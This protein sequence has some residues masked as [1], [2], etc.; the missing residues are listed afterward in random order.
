MKSRNLFS[1][2]HFAM[3]REA[4]KSSRRPRQKIYVNGTF[5]RGITKP[6]IFKLNVLLV[7]RARFTESLSIRLSIL[8]SDGALIGRWRCS[9]E[10]FWNHLV[11]QK[12]CTAT[13][14]RLHEV[15]FDLSQKN[16]KIQTTT[17]RV[18]TNKILEKWRLMEITEWSWPNPTICIATLK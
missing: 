3:R 18:T 13:R 7:L 15:C 4:M 9:R 10:F 16:T 2:I 17:T 12:W 1:H 14:G 11:K 8:P 6:F 5:Q